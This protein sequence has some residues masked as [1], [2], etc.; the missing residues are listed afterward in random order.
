MSVC[1][2]MNVSSRGL[3]VFRNRPTSRRQ[4]SDLVALVHIKEQ[5]RLSLGNYG[6]SRMTAEPKEISLNVGHRSVG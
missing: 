1:H 4:R 6:R 2:V 3:N 5:W